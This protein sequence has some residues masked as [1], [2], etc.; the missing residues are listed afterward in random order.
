MSMFRA[1]ATATLVLAAAPVLAQQ[2]QSIGTTA[3]VNP[4][5]RGFPP[6]RADRILTLGT[7]V[8]LRERVETG[9]VG[10]AQLMFQDGTA[11]TLGPNGAL[12]LDEFVYDPGSRRGRM[13][14]TA[15]AG[16]MRFVGGRVSKDE[17]AV[18][19]TPL[20]HVG[21][22]GGVAVVNIDGGTITAALLYGEQLR[23]VAANGAVSLITQPGFAIDLV[24]AGPGDARR[25]ARGELAGMM[26]RLDGRPGAN[27]G[28]GA[29]AAQRAAAAASASG[30]AQ[31]NSVRGSADNLI[32]IDG[33]TGTRVIEAAKVAANLA[34]SAR[35]VTEQR[36]VTERAHSPTTVVV[37][38][39]T[40]M[41]SQPTTPTSPTP[42]TPTTGIPTPG[43]PTGSATYSGIYTAQV[44][45]NNT[46]VVTIPSAPLSAT[47]NFGSRTGTLTL[48]NLD[49]TTY[50]GNITGTAVGSAD[51]LA[52]TLTANNRAG[53]TGTLV[54]GSNIIGATTIPGVTSIMNGVVNSNSPDPLVYRFIAG[55]GAVPGRQ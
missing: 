36:A 33:P 6:A 47:Y 2:T 4:D 21:I 32:R 43:L 39:P 5:T 15:A 28:A 48:S 52:G 26:A 14:M 23:V 24:A 8:F 22:R 42:A 35:E 18:I 38:T 1:I 12:T 46:T 3:A 50:S 27:G 11:V 54:T 40:V 7:D 29:G 49:G 20:G 31:I 30:L 45:I 19:R 13:V 34:Q 55:F 44:F 41:P 53:V 10:Q 16:L 17:E 37:T 25:L 51:V 9:P